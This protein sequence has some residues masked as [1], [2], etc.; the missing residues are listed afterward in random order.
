[1]YFYFKK[2]LK[3]SKSILLFVVSIS[4]ANSA[5]EPG[6]NDICFENSLASTIP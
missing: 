5:I 3:F 6:T 2:N 4:N 1:V